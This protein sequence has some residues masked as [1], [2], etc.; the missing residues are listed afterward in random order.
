MVSSIKK[1]TQGAVP[2]YRQLL[3]ILR[4]QI[5]SGEIEPGSQIPTEDSLI[6]QYGIS[7]GTV[8]KAIE[9][10]EAEKLIY[11]EHGVGS[12]VRKE[13][14]NAVPFHFPDEIILNLY[15]KENISYEDVIK[16]IIPASAEVAE[17]LHLSSG[18]LVLHIARRLLLKGKPISY[19]SRYIPEA[20]CPSLMDMDLSKQSIHNVLIYVSEIPLLRAELE[21][22]AHMVNE[23]E[24]ELLQTS[25]KTA[26]IIINRVTYTAPNRP[27]VWFKGIYKNQHLLN[28][29]VQTD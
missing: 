7:R 12:F 28:I 21:I 27:A 26:A 6:A 22:E 11:K 8:R 20:L 24:A 23:E 1:I 10:L 29:Q 13:H 19:T 2:K 17:K 9:Q 3:D 14:S 25:K 5:I 4:N 18:E 16:E 15:G